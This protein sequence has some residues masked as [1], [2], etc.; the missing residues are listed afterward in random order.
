MKKPKV[1]EF[2][3]LPNA[4]KSSHIK[5]LARKL[6]ALGIDIGVISDQIWQAPVSI[7]NDEIEKIK[8]AIRQAANLITATKKEGLD[9]ILIERGGWA[10]LASLRA[11]FRNGK[12]VRSKKQRKIA[13][14]AIR[15]ALDLTHDED[16]FVLI[17]IPSQVALQRD[18]ELGATQ[19]GKIVNPS[20]L[21]IMEEV[22]QSVQEKLPRH[23]RRIIDGQESFEKNQEKILKALI[24]LVPRL[25]TENQKNPSGEIK[26][27]GE[28]P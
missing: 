13:R 24:S 1:V 25:K 16:F 9:L 21:P 7:R 5:H 28:T 19:P 14:R 27:K 17:N 12:Q 8:W 10:H 2:L 11:H 6:D 15:L 26:K 18:Q 22:Y 20:F 3:G 23:R 4:G